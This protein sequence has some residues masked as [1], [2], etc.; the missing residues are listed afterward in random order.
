M[1]DFNRRRITRSLFMIGLLVVSLWAPLSTQA[2]A[3]ST[4]PGQTWRLSPPEVS[5]W[6]ADALRQADD[7]ARSMGTDAYLV[8]HHGAIVHQFGDV[9]K[10]MNLFSGRKS[11]LSVLYG[12]AVDRQTI[13]LNKTLADLGMEDKF[14]LTETEKAATI[15]QLLQARSGVYHPAAYETAAMKAAIRRKDVM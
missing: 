1:F 10:P 9:S 3:S 12:I 5:Q 14:A 4:F 2:D 7:L 15:R 13:D 8:V 6:S 11:V